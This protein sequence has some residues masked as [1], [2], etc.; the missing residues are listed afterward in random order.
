MI[1]GNL[2]SQLEILSTGQTYYIHKLQASSSGCCVLQQ[3]N[4][5]VG[6]ATPRQKGAAEVRQL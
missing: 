6:H 2:P 5:E 1:P 4:K 3:V